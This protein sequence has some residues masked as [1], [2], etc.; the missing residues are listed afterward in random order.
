MEF[1][2]VSFLYSVLNT[3]IIRIYSV[4]VWNRLVKALNELGIQLEFTPLEFETK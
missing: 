1:E 3:K 4:G 2:T